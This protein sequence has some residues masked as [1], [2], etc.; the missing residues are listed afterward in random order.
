M[1]RQKEPTLPTLLT[2]PAA[3]T[4]PLPTAAPV[5]G[6]AATPLPARPLPSHGLA[7]LASVVAELF[8]RQRT[9]A[10][11]GV[12]MLA[13][14]LPAAI[15]WGLD[16]RVLR[17]ASVWVKPLKFMLSVAVLA[18]TTAWFVGHLPQARRQGRGVRT[19]V[20]LVVGAGT[21]EVGYITLQ[22]ALGQASHYNVGD[23]LHAT[24]YTLMGVGAVL[25]AGSQPLLAALLWRW[26]DIQRP[27]V[28]RLAVIAGLVLA[29]VL[30]GGVGMVLSG[31]LPSTA[32]G[33]PLLGWHLQDDLRPAH[34]VGM[35]A[36]QALPLAGAWLA[37]RGQGR[38][39]LAAVAAAY[40]L[41]VL[42]LAV[43]GWAR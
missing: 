43:L 11:F 24:M 8:K 40:V 29:F 21:F 3:A 12:V 26:P 41:A 19:V 1:P 5:A 7:R 18:W 25:L 14:M 4:A 35:H 23:P 42:G 38:R 33:L 32:P 15:A 37:R 10:V 34:F 30:G 27:P 2:L 6:A 31:Q 17:G 36:A 9:L 20:A 28:L 22:A 16:E 13:A 39:W